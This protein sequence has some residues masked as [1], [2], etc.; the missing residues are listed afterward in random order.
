MYNCT[1]GCVFLFWVFLCFYVLLVFVQ[2]FCVLLSVWRFSL[3]SITSSSRGS[4]PFDIL[5]VN[6]FLNID[7]SEMFCTI[8]LT[9]L[10]CECWP[11][12]YQSLTYRV[13]FRHPAGRMTMAAAPITIGY[14]ATV[15]SLKRNNRTFCTSI[16][17]EFGEIL[18]KRLYIQLSKNNILCKIVLPHFFLWAQ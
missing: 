4:C 6:N 9:C 2:S 11:S 7:W 17:N 12:W 5:S 14:L 15:W 13:I 8:R 3:C 1:Q 10:V 16:L 18:L